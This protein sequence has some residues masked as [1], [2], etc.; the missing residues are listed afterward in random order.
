MSIVLTFKLTI[1]HVDFSVVTQQQVVDLKFPTDNHSEN[2]VNIQTG[3]FINSTEPDLSGK[4]G[5]YYSWH[6]QRC[7][8]LGAFDL[9]R[10]A[11]ILDL[12]SGLGVIDIIAAK[13][14]PEARFWLVDQNAFTYDPD[15]YV[16]HGADHPW[17]NSWPVVED[18]VVVNQLARQ[19]FVLQPPDC[20]WPQDLD[21]VISTWCW[22]WHVPFEMYW[23]QVL[24]S[25]KIGGRLC[26][27][28]RQDHDTIVP[29]ISDELGQFPS[30][31]PYQGFIGETQDHSLTRGA[32]YVWQRYR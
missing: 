8:R 7:E 17:Y 28:I 20:A 14:L 9:T 11:R 29:M 5:E 18:L 12:G 22:C 15:Y 21:L 10:D 16:R 26:M 27:D 32:R 2:L 30:M 4:L 3:N 6:W 23:P 24:Q 31:A 25:L 13:L 1:P 19:R